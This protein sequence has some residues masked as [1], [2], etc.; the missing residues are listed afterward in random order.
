MAKKLLILAAIGAFALVALLG[1]RFSAKK[2]TTTQHATAQ[3]PQQPG[4]AAQATP[5]DRQ[6]SAAQSVI[7]RQPASAKGYN[8]LAAAYMQKARETGDFGLNAKAQEALTRANEAEPEN[9]DALKLR[10]KLLLTYHRFAEA[11]EVAR[12]AQALSPR[13]HD[14]YGAM[15]DALVELGDYD[16]AVES[17]QT[18]IDLRPDVASYSRV[19]YLRELHGDTQGAVEAMRQAVESAGPQDAESIA[20]CR[21]HLG[22]ELVRAGREAE[23]EREY[24]HA[25]FV[26][27]NYH[28]ALAAKARARLAAGDADAAADFYRRAIERVPLPDYAAALGDLYTKL[29]RAEDAR[30]QY[31]LVEFVERTGAED[32]TYTRRLA[33]FWADHDTRL[34][35]ALDVAR[36]ERA[37]RTDIYT[38]DLL[39]WCLYKKGQYAEAK[40]SADEALRLGTRDP[41]LLYHAGMIARALGDRRGGAKYLQQALAINPSFDVLQADVAR[42][43]LAARAA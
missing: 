11:L 40:A 43:T 20:W 37:A 39:A 8:L 24:D 41:L 14:V 17:A 25:L 33:M 22:D 42:R 10:A 12:R 29:G 6:I 30:R 31:E 5:G 38:S 34:D 28:T 4:N 2:T 7:E 32:G 35:E 13:D 18:M 21:V 9:Y 26:F 36:R 1:F 23:A 16:Q 27:P 19:S 15:T 3:P